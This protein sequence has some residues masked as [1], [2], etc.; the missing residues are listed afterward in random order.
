MMKSMVVGCG[1]LDV[2]LTGLVPN[3]PSDEAIA[4]IAA[5]RLCPAAGVAVA[6]RAAVA[7]GCRGRLAGTVGADLLGQI[8]K[9]AP[10]RA[11]IDTRLVGLTGASA[12]EIHMIGVEGEHRFRFPGE[13]PAVELDL[14]AMVAD[15][16]ALLLD[17]TLAPVAFAAAEHARARKI[18]VI[19]QARELTPSL[20]ELIGRA[21]VLITN[22]LAAAELAPQG[23]LVDALAAFAAMGPSSVVI[24]LGSAGAIGRHD[25][26]VVRVQAFPADVLDPHGAG[27]VFQGVFAAARCDGLTFAQ[28][29][30]LASAAAAL[31]CQSLGP[32]DGVPQGQRV[33]ELAK[34]R[35]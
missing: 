19:L 16:A 20:K 28:G 29:L 31:S 4:D 17:G 26:Q 21:D 3:L 6:V 35:R 23:E 11:G 12:C 18:P 2:G 25:H 9:V 5:L 32:W 33:R 10:E 27:S 30:E 14:D 15:A 1:R 13:S 24:T 8:A 7:M 22:E 34:S